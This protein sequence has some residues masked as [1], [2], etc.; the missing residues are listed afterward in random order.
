MTQRKSKANGIY[1]KY[2][3]RALD[4]FFS[5]LLGIP[6]AILLVPL[7]LL[8]KIDDPEHHAFFVQ[9]R[10]GYKGKVFRIFK[11]R[12]MRPV[13]AGE[14][15][16]QYPGAE[17]LTKIGKFLR[18]TSLDELPQLWNVFVGEM[19]FIGP[20]PLIVEYLPLYSSEQ[21]RRHDVLP[22]ITGWAQANGRNA[23]RWEKQFELDVWYVDHIS[24][25]VDCETLVLTVKQLISQ[26][27]DDAWEDR[28]GAEGDEPADDS[29]FN[30]Y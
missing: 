4:V 24:F 1:A 6:T 23:L 13:E 10:P 7:Y 30:Q 14:D 21:M 22:G 2:V 19:S 26:R 9:K 8:I 15:A 20:R 3:K 17:R 16:P 29:P 28:C 11:L 27:G 18:K 5:V 25:L 12:T